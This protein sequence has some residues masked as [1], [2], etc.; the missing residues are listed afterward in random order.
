M[1]IIRGYQRDYRGQGKK[2]TKLGGVE[3]A[4]RVNCV[5][6]RCEKMRESVK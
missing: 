2:N 1:G 5:G 3:I 6:D 4:G